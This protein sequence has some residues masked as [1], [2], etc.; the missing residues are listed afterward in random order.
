MAGPRVIVAEEICVLMGIRLLCLSARGPATT[1][2]RPECSQASEAV[3]HCPLTI[4]HCDMPATT[5]QLGGC[6]PAIPLM[7]TPACI[8]SIAGS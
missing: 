7:A 8:S 1:V 5:C 2:S 4:N 3:V 6:G